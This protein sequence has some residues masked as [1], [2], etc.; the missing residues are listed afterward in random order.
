M[1]KIKAFAK[2]KLGKALI[3]AVLGGCAIVAQQYGCSVCVD[4]IDSLK[5]VPV[6]AQAQ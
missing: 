3:L 5:P 4:V 6:E 2:S 1:E